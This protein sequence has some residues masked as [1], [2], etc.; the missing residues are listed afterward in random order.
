[1]KIKVNRGLIATNGDGKPNF[2]PPI[3]A[4]WCRSLASSSSEEIKPV[5]FDV[6]NTLKSDPTMS[7][8]EAPA[9]ESQGADQSAAEEQETSL[10]PQ[11]VHR[12]STKVKEPENGQESLV[13]TSQNAEESSQPNEENAAAESSVPSEQSELPVNTNTL[14]STSPS[15]TPAVSLTSPAPNPEASPPPDMSSKLASVSVAVNDA[16]NSVENEDSNVDVETEEQLAPLDG[17]TVAVSSGGMCLNAMAANTDPFLR[18]ER[19]QLE[20]PAASHSVQENSMASNSEFENVHSHDQDEDS[21]V[22]ESDAQYIEKQVVNSFLHQGRPP[23]ITHTSNAHPMGGSEDIHNGPA[24]SSLPTLANSPLAMSD[25]PVTDS[26]VGDTTPSSSVGGDN[27][28]T[29]QQQPEK[30]MDALSMTIASVAAGEGEPPEYISKYV[31]EPTKSKAISPIRQ[32][33]SSNKHKKSRADRPMSASARLPVISSLLAPTGGSPHQANVLP[34]IQ[35]IA[36]SGRGTNSPNTVLPSVAHFLGPAKSPPSGFPQPQHST[37]DL[38]PHAG[39]LGQY[40][41]SAGGNGAHPGMP[42]TPSQSSG[43]SSKGSRKPVTPAGLRLSMAASE[44]LPDPLPVPQYS[45]KVIRA[46]QL[47]TVAFDRP[48][49]LRETVQ[50]FLQY[51][52]YW[53]SHDYDRISNLVIELFPEFK[54]N[55]DTPG[56]PANKRIRTDLS[57]YARNF[58]RR[59]VS[60]RKK[61][62]TPS[63]SPAAS[64]MDP[65]KPDPSISPTLAG[66]SSAETKSFLHAQASPSQHQGQIT[67]GASAVAAANPANSTDFCNELLT[68]A[69]IIES[70]N[71]SAGARNGECQM[72]HNHHKAKASERDVAGLSVSVHK[73]QQGLQQ[74]PLAPSTTGNNG[75]HTQQQRGMLAPDDGDNQPIHF[76]YDKDSVPASASRDANI[77]WQPKGHGCHSIQEVNVSTASSS[78]SS[79]TTTTTTTTTTATTA[80]M[81]PTD[82]LSAMAMWRSTTLPDPLPTP[83]YSDSVTRARESGNTM[84]ARPKIIRETTQFFLALKLWWTAPDYERIAELVLK[85]FPALVSLQAIKKDLGTCARNMRRRLPAAKYKPSASSQAQKSA[86]SAGSGAGAGNSGPAG[87]GSA[88]MDAVSQGLDPAAAGSAEYMKA[89]GMNLSELGVS[90]RNLGDLAVLAG[91]KQRIEQH[92]AEVSDLERQYL[93]QCTTEEQRQALLAS[94]AFGNDSTAMAAL[95][96]FYGQLGVDIAASSGAK[97]GQDYPPAS[98]SGV[99][100]SGVGVQDGGLGELLV[101]PNKRQRRISQAEVE[102]RLREA[103]LN[104]VSQQGQHHLHHFQ[105]LQ[106][107]QQQQ[108]LEVLPKSSAHQGNLGVGVSDKHLVKREPTSPTGVEGLKSRQHQQHNHHSLQQHQHSHSQ[109]Q[110]PHHQHQPHHQQQQQQLTVPSPINMSSFAVSNANGMG[111]MVSIP[112]S[113]TSSTSVPSSAQDQAIYWDSQAAASN[114]ALMGLATSVAPLIMATQAHSQHLGGHHHHHNPHQALPTTGGHTAASSSSHEVPMNLT[115][116]EAEKT[117]TNSPPSQ[118]AS[119]PH[120]QAHQRQMDASPSMTDPLPDTASLAAQVEVTT[121]SVKSPRRRA[122]SSPRSGSQHGDPSLSQRDQVWFPHGQGFKKENQEVVCLPDPLPVPVY[123]QKIS[124]AREEGTSMRHRSEIIRETARFFL[125]LKYWW[126]SADYTRISELVVQHFPDLKDDSTGDGMNNYVSLGIRR[127]QRDLSMCARNLRRSKKPRKMRELSSSDLANAMIVAGE[128]SNQ[129]HPGSVS[130]NRKR[131]TRPKGTLYGAAAERK[132]KR[133]AG[134]GVSRSKK[135]KS[136]HSRSKK[137]KSQHAAAVVQD[138]GLDPSGSSTAMHSPV[139]GSDAGAVG[140]T[141]DMTAAAALMQQQFMQQSSPMSGAQGYSL[142]GSQHPSAH[143]LPTAHLMPSLHTHPALHGQ[144][145][146]QM[147]ASL[148]QDG[149]N[150]SVEEAHSAKR[151]VKEEPGGTEGLEHTHSGQTL[152]MKA[153]MVAPMQRPMSPT[154]GLDAVGQ[155]SAAAELAKQRVLRDMEEA[156]RLS[157]GEALLGEYIQAQVHPASTLKVYV[158]PDHGSDLQERFSALWRKGKFFDASLGVANKKLHVHKLVL[159]AM[160]PY[161]QE[162]FKNADPRS[163]LEVNLPSDTTYETAKAFLKYIYEGVLEV[164]TSSVRSLHKIATMLQ[165]N[166]LAQYCQNFAQQLQEET[167]QVQIVKYMTF[168]CFFYIT[169]ALQRLGETTAMTSDLQRATARYVTEEHLH[170]KAGYLAEAQQQAEA[171]GTTQPHFLHQD[172]LAQH[173]ALVAASSPTPASHHVSQHHHHHQNAGSSSSEL[174]LASAGSTSAQDLATQHLIQ[175]ALARHQAGS[176]SGQAVPVYQ[177]QEAVPVSDN[178]SAL[179]QRL[180]SP[181]LAAYWQAHTLSELM[182]RGGVTSDPSSQTSASELAAIAAAAAAATT[183]SSSTLP[184][185]SSSSSS[186]SEDQRHLGKGG[187]RVGGIHPSHHHHQHHHHHQYQQHHHHHQQQQTHHQQQHQHKESQQWAQHPEDASQHHH[188]HGTMLPETCLPG[189]LSR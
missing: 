154:I 159:L 109:Q 178:N 167:E 164:D 36:P 129:H 118:S 94:G 105:Q 156:G 128:D 51:K 69:S 2:R 85:N 104:H 127:I 114:M 62:G 126:S 80:S 41:S 151:L 88:A 162:T 76:V 100:V 22:A 152:S 24:G 60:Q 148:L 187:G 124:A 146:S 56:V 54:D 58:R 50:F 86:W 147:S 134:G 179:L 98:T 64:S 160:S 107:Q 35:H 14:S 155:S 140:V 132:A 174:L 139:V 115:Y 43:K 75:Y 67:G 149:T 48:T 93:A 3:P 87:C 55:S 97:R 130:E 117:E 181:A 169:V 7:S 18:E 10:S 168:P 38:L 11:D 150:I 176:P 158:D 184:A 177:Q 44:E 102:K 133:Q 99:G 183:T 28:S 15:S 19:N 81:A 166:K 66:P 6:G 108:H 4:G 186:S 144:H 5:K 90:Q 145:L 103:E 83:H 110:Q 42:G 74:E 70:Q 111:C 73:Q 112:S 13:S 29:T 175:A 123:S 47:G 21:I 71:T 143:L 138:A 142:S 172:A 161:L 141:E 26:G 113:S 116:H 32:G 91:I 34:G 92:P 40:Q 49:V 125:G 106:Q 131:P 27:G 188:H 189:D 173:R 72:P 8:E 17:S 135:A 1:M 82:R 16:P 137:A 101:V 25:T 96:A 163:Q 182:S 63:L 23:D 122:S 165:M 59:E 78:S 180:T 121:S 68:A 185:L 30:I 95:S 37:P 20:N 33:H 9:L 53:S 57:M 84:S 52:H 39:D 45:D 153:N 120:H 31:P 77:A 65:I 157:W 89:L 136:Q 12:G 61:D 119:N 170:F 46:K 79:S 171:G